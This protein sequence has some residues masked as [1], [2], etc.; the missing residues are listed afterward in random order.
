MTSQTSRA[1]WDAPAADLDAIRQTALDY[2]E[3]W[4]AGDGDRRARCLH[5]NLAKRTVRTHPETGRST[6]ELMSATTLVE[7]TRSGAGKETPRERQQ[8]DVTILDV[9]G[10]VASVKIVAAGWVDYLH[11][12]KFNGEWVIVNVLWERKP[13]Q[14]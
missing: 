4:Y 3:S 10:N 7:H 5:P 1:E 13:G 9:F 8:K 12:A 6:L 14:V 11:L 2:I